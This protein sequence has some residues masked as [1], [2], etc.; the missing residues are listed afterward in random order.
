MFANY[1]GIDFGTT[2][3]A[4]SVVEDNKKPSLITFGNNKT[5]IPTAIFFPENNTYKPFFGHQAVSLYFEGEEGRFMR[6]LKR[7]LGTD[8]MNQKTEVNNIYMDYEDIILHFIKYLKQKAESQINTQLDSVVLGRPVH[9]QDFAPEQDVIAESVLRKIAH[10]AG[11]KNISFQ[12]EPIA[13][14]YTHE[15]KLEKELLACVI[16]IGGGTSDFSII[17]LGKK[18]SAKDRA[19]DI[20][21]NT[22]IRIGGNDFDANLS[23]KCFMHYLGY[24]TLQKPNP[25]TNR[26]LPVPNQPYVMLSEWSSINSLY[27]YKERKNIKEIYDSSAE[28][29]KVINLY[30]IADKELGHTLL[31]KVEESKI[32]LTTSQTITTQLHF[33]SQKPTIPL[34]VDN[35]E[36]SIKQNVQKITCSLEECIKS[37]GINKE[38]IGLVILTGGST[39]IPYIKNTI[40][41][42]FPNARISEDNKLSSVATGLSYDAMRLYK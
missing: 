30:E 35:F 32:L 6:S 16:D 21:A 29:H 17:R 4:I 31:N 11:F 39:E 26:I 24:E 1:C 23:L 19:K 37:A 28:P 38:S 7:I 3:S 15:I 42:M 14:A 41:N 25:Y 20:L 36:N 9:F 2:N 13:A 5:T 40:L 10:L 22:G 27:T 12:Y 34:A 33:L 8:L 18:D